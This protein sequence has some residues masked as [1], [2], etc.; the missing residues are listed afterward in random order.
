LKKIL[1][2]T[3]CLIVLL[4]STALA[5]DV[6]SENA[7]L[8]DITT[9]RTITQQNAYAKAYPASTT[10]IMTAILALEKLSLSDKLVASENAVLSVPS[11]GSIADIQAGEELSVETLLEALLVVSANEAA[12][13]LAEGISGSIEE[14]VDL[15]NSKANELDLTLTHFVNSNGLHNE[16]HYSCAYDVAKMYRYAYVTFPDFRRIC[17]MKTISIPK[18]SIYDKERTFTNSNKMII[19]ESKYYYDACTGGKTGYTS[20]ARNCLVASASKNGIELIV[21]VLGGGQT[22]E[23]ESQRYLD[24]K[25]LFE[26]GFSNLKVKTIAHSG[27][28]LDQVEVENSKDKKDRLNLVLSKPVTL[29]IEEKDLDKDFEPKITIVRDMVAPI[30]SRRICW[31]SH[32]QRIRNNIRC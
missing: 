4:A 18:T 14:F 24:T 26:Y 5:V 17:A 19:D 22:E 13:V 8:V 9:G 28:I 12:N 29:S 32:I 15:M 3:I 6:S 27:D 11:G 23:G 31:Q 7:I 21:C 2:L 16:N 30:S 1:F 20:E 25:N 10:K